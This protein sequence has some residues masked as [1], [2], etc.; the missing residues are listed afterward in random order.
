MKSPVAFALIL[1]ASCGNESRGGSPNS[2]DTLTLARKADTPLEIYTYGFASN[3]AGR[4][5]ACVARRWGFTY[6][7]IAGCVVTKE[8]V[9]SAAKHNSEVEKALAQKHG[10]DWKGRFESEVAEAITLD[11]MIQKAALQNSTIATAQKALDSAGKSFLFE[12]GEK[13]SDG[14]IE[15]YAYAYDEWKG[16]PAFVTYFTLWVDT[17]VGQADVV[18]SNRW[19]FRTLD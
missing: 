17:S 4:S 9:D 6:R 7:T 18:N 19:L 12:P 3:G 1:L 2:G 15:V 16:K 8:L 14:R 10:P 13:S 11:T 5:R